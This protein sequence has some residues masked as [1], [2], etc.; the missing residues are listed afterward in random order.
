MSVQDIPTEQDEGLFGMTDHLAIVG[1][2][3]H[4]E[5][6]EPTRRGEGIRVVMSGRSVTLLT[7][8]AFDLGVCATAFHW[9]EED[10]ALAKKAKWMS[11]ENFTTSSNER[12]SL[13]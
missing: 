13:R 4:T 9:L 6:P 1:I 2:S 7:E 3:D 12:F 10:S 8:S 11:K 5:F